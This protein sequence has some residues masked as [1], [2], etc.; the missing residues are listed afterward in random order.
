MPVPLRPE[1]ARADEGAYGTVGGRRILGFSGF[2]VQGCGDCLGFRVMVGVFRVQGSGIKDQ[3][4]S[5]LR[6]GGPFPQQKP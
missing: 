1:P 4:L 3:V 6:G 2:R 5:F